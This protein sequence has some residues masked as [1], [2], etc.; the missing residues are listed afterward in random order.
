M[1]RYRRLVLMTL[2]VALVAPASAYASAGWWDWL[3]KLSGPG[4]FNNG[5]LLDFRLF[6]QV[7][8][9]KPNPKN[10]NALG[11]SASWTK[12]SFAR[13]SRGR[14]CL[15]NA[16]SPGNRNLVRS[17]FEVRGGRITTEN[18]PLFSDVPGEFVGTVAAHQVMGMFMRQVDPMLAVGAGAGWMWFS[19]DNLDG[20]PGRL[21]F[22]PIVVAIAPLKV[23][24]GIDAQK[25]GAFTIR[26][27][28]MML[29][30]GLEASDFNARSR[31]TFKTRGDLVTSVS[32]MVDVLAL[33]ARP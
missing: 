10:P 17:Y 2:V 33:F 28:E 25:A 30:G 22:T 13:G 7:D 3:D 8:D 14:Q 6:C 31:S 21:V 29:V 12:T 11:E 15:T 5:F 20:R 1:K 24:P 32:L 27:E 16:V 19:G 23:L 4:P 9:D 18:Q 26:V